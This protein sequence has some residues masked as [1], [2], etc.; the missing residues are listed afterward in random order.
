MS[1]TVLNDLF[2]VAIFGLVPSFILPAFIK[3][4]QYFPNGAPTNAFS[5]FNSTQYMTQLFSNASALA[6]IPITS[7]KIL[8][9]DGNYTTLLANPTALAAIPPTTWI[10]F[11]LS[12]LP[13]GSNKTTLQCYYELLLSQVSLSQHLCHPSLRLRAFFHR[14]L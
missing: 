11:T 1:S 4:L 7:W 13:P 12:I 10:K 8:S 5:S 9:A 14:A 2:P 6:A 3:W